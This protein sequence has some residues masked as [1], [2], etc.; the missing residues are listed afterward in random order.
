MSDKNKK[1]LITGFEAYGGRAGNPSAEIATALDNVTINNAVVRGVVLPVVNHHLQATVQDLLHKENPTAV[2]ALG[3]CPGEAMIRLERLA[4]NYSSFNIPDNAGEQ[5]TGPVVEGAPAAYEST[6]P[7][8]LIKC[9]LLAAGIPARESA[10]AGTYLCNAIMFSLLHQIATEQRDCPCGFVH[11][12]LMPSQVCNLVSGNQS[13]IDSH[14]QNSMASM[15]LEMQ[16][17]AVEMVVE[18]IQR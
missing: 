6:L 8:Q 16:Q 11:L 9:T 10:T 18:L 12:P 17:R 13:V 2:I 14:H 5:Y 4:A 1:I 3:L 15:A 7:L